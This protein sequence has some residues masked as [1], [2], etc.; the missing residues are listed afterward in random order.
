MGQITPE[1]IML[2]I[3]II[4]I[5][6]RFAYDVVRSKDL[7]LI[8]DKMDSNKESIEQQITSNHTLVIQKFDSFSGNCDIHRE[9]FEEKIE[10]NEV[11]INKLGKKVDI[12][13][14]DRTVHN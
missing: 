14:Q 12:H 5:M 13:I 9:N 11:D 4:G 1:K 10:E 2:L 8:H 6:G 3:V 7:K